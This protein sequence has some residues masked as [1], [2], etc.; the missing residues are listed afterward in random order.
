MSMSHSMAVKSNTT[1]HSEFTRILLI[2]NKI[3]IVTVNNLLF[4]NIFRNVCR[5]LCVNTKVTGN[6]QVPQ[7]FNV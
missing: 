4:I 7:L 5:G 3:K 2:E 6:F 1:K